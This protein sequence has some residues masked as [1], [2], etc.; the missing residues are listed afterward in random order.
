VPF[1]Y[2]PLSISP[3]EAGVM[4][5]E[6]ADANDVIAE[7]VELARKKYLSI[8][9]LAYDNVDK[10]L[11]DY[12]L[13]KLRPAD[14]NL[15]RPQAYLLKHLFKSK[16]EVTLTSLKG[17]FFT[18][19]EETK[20]LLVSSLQQE[21]LFFTRN[22][23]ASKAFGII[24]AVILNVFVVWILSKL[25]QNNDISLRT[26]PLAIYFYIGYFKLKQLF[27]RSP[28]KNILLSVMIIILLAMLLFWLIVV[29][30]V[31]KP[32]ENAWT[33]LLLV[34]G[35]PLCVQLGINLAQ[36]SA[37]GTN[38]MLQAK[39]LKETLRLAKWRDEIKEK[40]LFIE[41]IIPYSIALGVIDKLSKDMDDLG[42]KPPEYVSRGFTRG[43]TLNTFT[44]G[45]SSSATSSLAYNPSSSSRSSGSGF[46][47]GSSGGGGGGGGGG[48]W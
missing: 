42:I 1:V 14:D 8:D 22:P 48:S 20:K 11:S 9:F 16:N 31:F 12:T 27:M 21:K 7:I 19:F 40:N 43:T 18:H 46:S 5:D 17:N 33:F 13:K 37:Q 47:G 2:E 26:I 10:V 45:F 36:K 35:F 6:K 4:L 44:N 32:I 24:F 28:K 38:A 15:T 39:G 3:G 41:A 25:L 23:R 30:V 34:I 29:F